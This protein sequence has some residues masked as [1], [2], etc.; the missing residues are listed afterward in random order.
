MSTHSSCNGSVADSIVQYSFIT[1][2]NFSF[3]LQILKQYWEWYTKFWQSSDEC[4]SLPPPPPPMIQIG[5]C[6]KYSC[7]ASWLWQRSHDS[8]LVQL[9]N[10]D[11]WTKT[12][13]AAYGPDLANAVGF[14]LWLN[15]I[16]TFSEVLDK[17]SI[18]HTNL[19]GAIAF[20][21]FCRIW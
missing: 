9:L 2:H 8:F 7:L 5:A 18:R 6:P 16:T 20:S 11:S 13:T 10:D 15:Q 14:S 21:Q 1:G 12:E 4:P 3:F 17:H 19:Y